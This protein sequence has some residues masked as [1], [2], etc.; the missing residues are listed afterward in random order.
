MFIP[1]RSPSHSSF[2]LEHHSSS[3]NLQL[4]VLN[5]NY[6]SVETLEREIALFINYY[7]N[8]RVHESLN[9][10]TPADMYYGRQEKI[11]SLRD[12]IKQKTLEER[13]RFN[14]SQSPCLA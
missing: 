11:L 14:L 6:Y 13:K 10:V 1:T 9:N 7:N 8:E 4:I 3:V 2:F 12:K 5:E